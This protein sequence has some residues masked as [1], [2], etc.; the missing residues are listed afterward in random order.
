VNPAQEERPELLRHLDA[1]RGTLFGID[2]RVLQS[3]RV[4]A[5][6]AVEISASDPGAARR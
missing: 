4:A 3:G 2:A 1:R 5:N 6:E